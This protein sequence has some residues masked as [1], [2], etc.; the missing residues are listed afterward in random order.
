MKMM[1]YIL[2]V[3]LA[4]CGCNTTAYAPT[5]SFEKPAFT[6]VQPVP[7][8]ASTPNFDSGP[9]IN[10]SPPDNGIGVPGASPT[11]WQNG[12]QMH[13]SCVGYVCY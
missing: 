2:P 12:G 5:T 10:F 7:S 8:V 6:P 11:P 1:K 4:L 3:A 13:G 9:S